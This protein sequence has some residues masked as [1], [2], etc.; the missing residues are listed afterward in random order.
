MPFEQTGEP[1]FIVLVAQQHVAGDG[2]EHAGRRRA[3][4]QYTC[5]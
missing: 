5:F 3:F 1:G 4:P 2:V